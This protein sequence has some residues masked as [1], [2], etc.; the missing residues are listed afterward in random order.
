MKLKT[1]FLTLLLFLLFF[2]GSI[3]LISFI[4]MNSSLNNIRECSL[5][6]HYFIATSYA[7]DLKALEGRGISADNALNST[8]QSY[9]EY[10]GK[11]NVFLELS[12]NGKLLSSNIP[13]QKNLLYKETGSLQGKRILS[14]VEAGGK[15]YV[16]V[17]G[18]LP[19][20]YDS[21]VLS[22]LYDIS[23]SISSWNRVTGILFSIGVAISFILAICLILL[24]NR[25]FKPLKHIALV[26]GDIAK[27]D[28]NNRIPVKGKDELSEMAQSFNNMAGEIQN[29]MAELEK[30]AEQK[31]CFIDNFAHEL[32]TPLTTIYGYAEYIQKAAITEE[33]KLSATNYIMEESRR[34]QNLSNRLLSLAMLR[35]DE[36][37]FEEIN[38]RELLKYAVEELRKKAE[39]KNV[40]LEY[41]Y[42]FTS[43]TGDI[44]LLKCLLVN[45]TDNAVKACMSGGRVKLSAIYEK[46]NRALIIEDNGI[47]IS[48]EH[49]KH[50]TEAFYRVDKSRSRAEGGAGLGLALCRQIAERHNINMLFSSKPGEGTTVKLIFTT[51][52]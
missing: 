15:K 39:N 43:L 46:N 26:S 36:I 32:R 29:Q 1:Y 49:L 9:I 18:T 30:S 17:A 19:A 34:L 20:P 51:L 52:K 40:E 2:N 28:Y 33:E 4:N 22:Y 25:I 42:D 23:P 48:E 12:R 6:E 37:R 27:G 14:T 45:L 50:I 10:Y 5:G 38:V 16:Y 8:F 24:L 41:V 31:Q 47:G 13:G 3:L 11:K 21:Y 7:K 35:N 44:E